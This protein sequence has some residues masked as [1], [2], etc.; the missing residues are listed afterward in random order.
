[1]NQ[2]RGLLD[3]SI[4]TPEGP[5]FQGKTQS[6]IFPGEKG[7]F[8]VLLNHK[9]LLSRL[10]KGEVVIEGRSIQV[11]RG[12]VQVALNQ[13]TAIVETGTIGN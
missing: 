11:R 10:M 3:V 6:V 7:V 2:A 1:M 5:L 4:L 8:E 13:V 9:P 12:I